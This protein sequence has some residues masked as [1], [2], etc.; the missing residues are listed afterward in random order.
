MDKSY[1]GLAVITCV[2]LN[3]KIKD[4]FEFPKTFLPNSVD[5]FKFCLRQLAL[6]R[7]LYYLELHSDLFR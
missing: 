5:H 7:E 2:L 4:V 1:H 6:K 3:R